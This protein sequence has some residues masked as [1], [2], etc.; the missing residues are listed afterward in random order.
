MTNV[1]SMGNRYRAVA[2]LIEDAAGAKREMVPSHATSYNDAV[3]LRCGL[4]DSIP[5]DVILQTHIECL[6][7]LH[8]ELGWSVVDNTVWDDTIDW[9]DEG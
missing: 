9:D 5:G 8:P 3:F 7:A 4:Y 6:S 2:I 1:L